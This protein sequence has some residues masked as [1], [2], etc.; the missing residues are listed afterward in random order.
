M[1][2]KKKKSTKRKEEQEEE[3][4]H[5]EDNR[6]RKKVRDK[7]YTL[8]SRPCP[9][10]QSQHEGQDQLALAHRLAIA[11][12]DELYRAIRES[13]AYSGTNMLFD[14]ICAR[15][16]MNRLQSLLLNLDETSHV[17]NVQLQRRVLF[18]E[19]TPNYLATGNI[20]DLYPERW[21]ELKKKHREEQK[22]LYE[23]KLAAMTTKYVCSKCKKKRV[24]Y[25]ELQTR[26]A[27]EPTTTFFNCLDCGHRWRN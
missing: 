24:T 9:Q 16:Y 3:I 5:E 14:K 1:A 8:L 23:Q 27:D 11:I 20:M 25:Y 6:M 13:S 26:S 19:V 21:D 10:W 2:T 17:K 12:E 18:Q 15:R 7:F 22:F 4:H